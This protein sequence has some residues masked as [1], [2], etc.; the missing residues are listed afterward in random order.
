MLFLPPLL[1]PP[2]QGL[3]CHR[4]VTRDVKGHGKAGEEE[5]GESFEKH[6]ALKADYRYI[7]TGKLLCMLL[8]FRVWEALLAFH[9]WEA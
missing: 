5:E 1:P 4:V 7:I 9:V 6:A 2:T 3:V 8:A